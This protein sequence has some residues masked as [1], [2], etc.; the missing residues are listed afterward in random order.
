MKTTTVEVYDWMEYVGP[1]LLKN[2]NE[3]L[4]A[5]GVEPLRDLHGG[6]FKDG[7]WVG[8]L[9]SDDYRNY[10]HSYLELWGERLHND[11]YQAMYFPEHDNDEEWEY[12]KEQLREWAVSHYKPTD[13]N[14]TDDLVTAM[15]KLVVEH[16]PNDEEIVF[17]WSW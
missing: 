8:V 10:W 1:E 16:F 5:K 14:W 3:L 15:R 2:L 7:R 11:N 6:S 17:K 9:E 12:C 13:P 4:V